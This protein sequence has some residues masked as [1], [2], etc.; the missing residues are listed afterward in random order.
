MRPFEALPVFHGKVAH[1]INFKPDTS[2]EMLETDLAKWTRKLI[3]SQLQTIPIN[4]RLLP[5]LLSQ[6]RSPFKTGDRIRNAGSIVGAVA[7]LTSFFRK[8]RKTRA[9]LDGLR[10]VRC[11]QASFLQQLRHLT[12]SLGGSPWAG[13]A[14]VTGTRKQG[15]LSLSATVSCNLEK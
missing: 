2:I 9:L 11:L 6:T 7:S 10:P 12:D 3:A 5:P 13:L 1:N 4:H 14:A 8:D 15:Q